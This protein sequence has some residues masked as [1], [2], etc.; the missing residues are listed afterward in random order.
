MS[1][2]ALFF[3][4][5]IFALLSFKMHIEEGGLEHGKFS[6]FVVLFLMN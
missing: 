2:I 1:D 3:V 5:L 6:P 4:V